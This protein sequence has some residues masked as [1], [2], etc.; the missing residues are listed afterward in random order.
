MCAAI[1]YDKRIFISGEIKQNF[2]S[3]G[4]IFI[5]MAQMGIGSAILG[6]GN[7]ELTNSITDVIKDGVN[8]TLNASEEV[9]IA[10]KLLGLNPFA[11]GVRFAKSA[12]T[13]DSIKRE[14]PDLFSKFKI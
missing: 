7:L 1:A 14:I 8:C 11:G 10:E 5:D 12:L 4:N 9:L 6:Y 3:D 13:G 2:D